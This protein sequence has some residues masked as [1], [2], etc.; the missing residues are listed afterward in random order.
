MS[1]KTIRVIALFQAKPGKLDELKRLLTQFIEP[2]CKEEG[3]LVYELH[4]NPVDPDDL[5]FIEE[6]KSHETLDAHL[7]SKH[8]LAAIP[9]VGEL[10]TKAPDIRRYVKCSMN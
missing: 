1:A 4:Q 9:L 2:T 8:I 10:V 6:W 7:K 5:A 3:C